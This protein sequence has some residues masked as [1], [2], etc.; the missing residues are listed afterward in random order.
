ME[1]AHALE[2]ARHRTRGVLCTL[3]ADGRPQL[4]N[5]LYVLGGASEP[6]GDVARIS[7]TA[8]RAKTRNLRRDPR[9]SLYVPGDDFWS[10]AVLEGEAELSPVAGS[11][12][13]PVADEL[14]AM[15]R[16]A[17][18]EHPDWADFRRAMV[19]ERRLVLRFRP[20]RAYGIVGR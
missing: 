15:Y 1:L 6:G 19:R 10:Y 9:A 14:A 4:S 7:V 2:F 5:I 13:D 20:A 16:Q 18:G 12:D 8:D 17:A 11:P 3:K